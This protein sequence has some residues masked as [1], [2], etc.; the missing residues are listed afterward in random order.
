MGLILLLIITGIL[1]WTALLRDSDNGLMLTNASGAFSFLWLWE[2][3]M[4]PVLNT[5][6][7][8]SIDSQ[9][10]EIILVLALTTCLSI[11]SLLLVIYHPFIFMDKEGQLSVKNILKFKENWL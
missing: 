8:L 5:I 1:S 6:Q 4:E 11:I 10:L 3:F 2:W 9:G 7:R